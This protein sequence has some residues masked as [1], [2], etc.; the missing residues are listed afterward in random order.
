MPLYIVLIG[1]CLLFTQALRTS[2]SA[3]A[4]IFVLLLPLADLLCLFVSRRFVSVRID[5]GDRVIRRGDRAMVPVRLR[6]DGL[7][8][9]GCAEV[10]LTVPDGKK[11]RSHSTVSRLSLPPFSENVSEVGAV[12]DRRGYFVIGVEEIFLYDFLRL[13]RIR[14]RINRQVAVRVLPRRLSSAGVLPP[15]D[16]NGSRR[17]DLLEQGVVSE[18]GDIREFRP[19]DGMKSIHWKLSTKLD[20]LQVRKYTSEADKELLVFADF[21][22]GESSWHFSADVSLASGDRIAE[23][24]L[25]AACDGAESGA[26]GRL[27]WF[28]P[29]GTPAVFSFADPAAAERIAFPLS[30]AEGGSGRFSLGEVSN[31]E[32]SVLY[33]TAYGSSYAEEAV[34]RVM[35]DAMGSPV[36]VALVSL[37]DLLPSEE[38]E[39]YRTELDALCRRLAENGVTVTVP[40]RK[41]GGFL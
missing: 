41:E 40:D 19:G 30:E 20:E 16:Q 25:T 22:L 33:V 27:Q 35:A 38:R 10:I 11:R 26:S 24:A 6:N 37:A 8:P 2:V 5:G 1:A 36:A 9:V 31:R 12:F 3:M 28:E 15:F 29:D 39:G 17:M 14:K 23:E 18:Y 34:R 21:A 13:I 32:V 7:L 4:W